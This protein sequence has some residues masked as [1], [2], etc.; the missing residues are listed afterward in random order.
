M[1]EYVNL[2]DTKGPRLKLV[3]I[4]KYSFSTMEIR[5]LALAL[6]M[7]TITMMAIQDSLLS[8]LGYI[9]FTIVFFLTVGLGFLLHELGHKF[10]AQYYGYLSEFRADG[11]MLGLAF[12]LALVS[13]FVFIAPGA[14]M[15]LGRPSLQKNGIISIAGPVVNLFLAIIFYITGL[16]IQGGTLGLIVDIGVWVNAFLGVF[17]MLPFWILDG[18]K[19]LM[20]SKTA[21]FSVL[22]PLIILMFL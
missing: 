1:A 3:K 10:V 17:N 4:G 7:I 9:Q 2:E 22:I 20:W 11:L 5:H 12:L 16:F 14:V 13:P 18:K 8:Q 6:F 19:V 21:Y 15:I